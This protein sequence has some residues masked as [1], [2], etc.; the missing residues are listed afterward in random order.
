LATCLINLLIF[1]FFSSDNLKAEY[2]KI[3]SNT[4]MAGQS[5]NNANK[6]VKEVEDK[7]AA[8][9]V[10]ILMFFLKLILKIFFSQGDI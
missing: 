8:L 6:I 5:A 2:I 3:T 9:K 1:N 4:K 7:H 10:K